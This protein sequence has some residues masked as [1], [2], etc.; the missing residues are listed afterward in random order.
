WPTVLHPDDLAIARAGNARHNET[1]EPFSLEYRMIAKDGRVVWVRD[2][3]V[4]IRDDRGQPLYSQGVMLDITER[5]RAEEQLAFLAYHD[6]LTGM[7]NGAMFEELLDLSL[8]RAR[9]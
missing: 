8:A 2:E 3:A 5:K 1:G 7:P 4:M 9:R 6:D